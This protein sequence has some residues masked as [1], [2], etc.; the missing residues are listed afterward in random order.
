M[1]GTVTRLAFPR[2]LELSGLLELPVL[3]SGLGI[4]RVIEDGFGLL[5][6]RKE[7]MQ[8]RVFALLRLYIQLG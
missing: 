5:Y 2:G 3:S 4:I 6:K 8:L 7:L 1:Q